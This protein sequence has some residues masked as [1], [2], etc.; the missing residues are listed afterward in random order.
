M[1][2]GLVFATAIVVVSCGSSHD[3]SSGPRDAGSDAYD[4]GFDPDTAGLHA[5]GIVVDPASATIDVYDGDV[6]KASAKFTLS[7]VIDDGSKRVTTGFCALDRF[8]LGSLDASLTF[9]ATGNSG[10]VATM[11]CKVGDF[12]AKATIAV[13]LHDTLDTGAGIDGGNKGALLGATAADPALDHLLY[14]Y[15]G[16]VFPRG[17]ASP[18]LMWDGPAPADVYALQFQLPGMDFTEFVAATAPM[19][20]TIPQAE[21]N[22]LLETAGSASTALTVT[23]RRLDGGAGGT[24][25]VSAK[26]TW[27]LAPAN[28]LGTVYY[29][30]IN[31]GRVVRLK[32]GASAPEDFLK[33]STG[34]ACVACHAVS[35]DGSQIVAAYDGGAGEWATFDARSGDQTFYSAAGSGFEAISPDASVVVAGQSQ[36]KLGL[37]DAKT[38]SSL[39]PSGIGA[40]GTA[41]HPTFSPDGKML[42]FGIRRDGTWLDFTQ[43]DLATAT[44]DP[45]TNQFG[46]I[47]MLR[48]G[49]GRVL[50]YP[51]FTPD[52]AWIAYM[53]ATNSKTRNAHGDLKLIDLDGTSDVVLDAACNG[54]VADADKSLSFEPTFNPVMLGGYFWMVFVSERSFGNRWTEINDASCTSDFSNC[55][56]KQLWV[57]A[58]DASPS[59]GVDPS[60]PAFW[61]PGQDL[62]DQNMRG[63]WALDPCK[64]AGDGCSAGFECCDGSCKETTP[65]GPKVCEKAPPG[66]CASIG[67]VCKTTSDCCDAAAGVECVGGVCGK[68]KPS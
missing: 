68:K 56:H 32:S 12:S 57:A 62:D 9:Q 52:G 63:Y 35:R 4:G 33:M 64:L 42:A 28:L 40:A 39:E 20:A 66:T 31:G 29:W 25:Y 38:G 21:W 1:K 58:I 49:G 14:P 27:T 46:P 53:D 7:Y 59:A 65:G 48:G 54:G 55:R 10:G 18:E 51:S 44:F 11:T 19:R 37:F 47:H 2:R 45:S 43:S 6:S 34:H 22:K 26:S 17:L 61:L 67:D 24:P 16:T 8:D 23:V 13:N 5:V 50:T 3:G 36:D 15:D 30:R 60:H 41:V